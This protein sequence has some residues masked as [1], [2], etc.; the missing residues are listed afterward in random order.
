ML[1]CK[2]VVLIAWPREVVVRYRKTWIGGVYLIAA[3]F[4]FRSRFLSFSGYLRLEAKRDK[5][6]MAILNSRMFG[7]KHKRLKVVRQEKL[8]DV[9]KRHRWYFGNKGRGVRVCARQDEGSFP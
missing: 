5:S 9:R 2:L 7:L 1:L 8:C 4:T 6:A 3:R